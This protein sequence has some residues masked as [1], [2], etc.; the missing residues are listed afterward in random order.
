MGTSDDEYGV[1]RGFMRGGRCIMDRLEM[2]GGVFLFATVSFFVE[3]PIM[4]GCL[5]Y[6]FVVETFHL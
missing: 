4:F 6:G 5:L 2:G 1:V 3:I